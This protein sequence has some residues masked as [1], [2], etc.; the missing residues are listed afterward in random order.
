MNLLP[1]FP[2]HAFDGRLEDVRR[3]LETK[4]SSMR[5]RL[6]GKTPH[7]APDGVYDDTSLDW[8][9]SGFWP[10]MLWIMYGLTG[11]QA[12]RD[13]AW[14]WD[15]RLETC[16]L[17]E[18]DLHHDVGFQFL[19]TAVL[20]YKLTG[21]RDAR[22][23]G[24]FAAQF[25]AGRFNPKGKFIRAW[26]EPTDS[27]GW[28]IVDSTMNLSLLYWAADESGDPRFRHVADAHAETIVE[29]FVRPD[30]SVRHICVFD[31]ETGQ[32]R[33][34]LGGQGFGPDSAWSRGTAWA[35]Y[36]L[37]NV[38]RYTGDTRFLDASKRVAH[39]FIS[40][41]EP[42]RVPLWDFRVVPRDDQPRDS[43]AAAIAASG[44]IELAALV[45]TTERPIYANAAR[46]ILLSLTDRYVDWNPDRDGVLLAG[47]GHMPEKK[48]INV[49][50]IYGDYYYVEAVAKLLGWP[51]RVF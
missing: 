16:F 12:W 18:S 48:N 37:A 10:G 20:K 51:Y 21:D 42:D 15:E 11:D 33:G 2:P 31:P 23:R 7:A 43:S 5:I 25:L 4:L 27:V 32:W 6:H 13:E 46:D 26:N 19:P 39:F 38:F 24:L 49:S 40:A 47:T 41:L 1:S 14:S 9:T 36:G 28:S 29:H 44:L 8:W 35:L 34:A 50:L 3:R 17:A 22:R 45:P 30:G